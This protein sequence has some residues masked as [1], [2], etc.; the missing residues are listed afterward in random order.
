MIRAIKILSVVLLLISA[1][2]LIRTPFNFGNTIQR[3]IFHNFLSVF[4]CAPGATLAYLVLQII[5][6]NY[7]MVKVLTI[8]TFLTIVFFGW[9]LIG[10]LLDW[11]YYFTVNL[12]TYTIPHS[13]FSLLFALL[14]VVFSLVTMMSIKRLTLL[15]NL[16]KSQKGS[17]SSV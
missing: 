9:G 6:P 1:Y 16:K 2:A 5:K 8:L 17:A 15:N 10:P 14:G 4:S 11:G 7:H 12:F 13:I 3:T